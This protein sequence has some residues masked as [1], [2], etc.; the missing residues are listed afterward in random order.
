[1]E[2]SEARKRVA[3]A[4]MSIEDCYYDKEEYFK[5]TPAQKNELWL[6]RKKRGHVTNK[7]K[8]KSAKSQIKSGKSLT[9]KQA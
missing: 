9:G 2:R 4:D 3:N 7:N 5:L 8:K 1:M 6:K